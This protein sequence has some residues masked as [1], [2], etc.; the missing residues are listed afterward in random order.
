MSEGIGSY[1]VCKFT[2]GEHVVPVGRWAR[3]RQVTA[4]T[5]GGQHVF[6]VEEI[7]VARLLKA[8]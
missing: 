5:D 8:S 6:F 1:H 4:A 3:V 7:M 2:H